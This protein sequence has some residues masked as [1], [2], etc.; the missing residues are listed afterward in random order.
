[1][2]PSAATGRTFL[3]TVMTF[4]LG[5]TKR[6]IGSLSRGIADTTPCEKTNDPTPRSIYVANPMNILARRS[7]GT[8]TLTRET[9]NV[10]HFANE[11]GKAGKSTA[12]MARNVI[13]SM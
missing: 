3:A 13:K 5:G 11:R 10:S 12:S 7:R 8:D 2:T 9:P 6:Y 4:G 1:M